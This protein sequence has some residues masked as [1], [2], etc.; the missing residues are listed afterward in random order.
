[1]VTFDVIAKQFVVNIEGYEPYYIPTDDAPKLFNKLGLRLKYDKKDLYL[2]TPYN[3]VK[4]EYILT[5]KPSVGNT[6]IDT[7]TILQNNRHVRFHSSINN[8]QANFKTW[9]TD[10]Y[11]YTL[12]SPE[13]I[14]FDVNL[15]KYLDDNR[16]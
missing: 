11:F 1:M 5:A 4:K 13:S 10:C 7:L 12:Y 14:D 3:I 16:K 15:K 9:T 8:L 2:V 6:K